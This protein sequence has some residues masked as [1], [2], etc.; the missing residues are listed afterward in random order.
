M[1]ATAVP[2]AAA[3]AASALVQ[4][5]QCVTCRALPERPFDPADVED[6]VEYR[7]RKPRPVVS[8]GPRSK[9]CKTHERAKERARKLTLRTG[10]KARTFGVPRAIQVALW[11][12]Q[13]SSCPC[14]RKRSTTIPAGV[15]LHHDRGLAR[16]HPHP[17]EEGCLDCVACFLCPSCNRD[18]IGRL[19]RTYR[20][21]ALV[22]AALRSLA[23]YIADP[24]LRRLRTERPD[25][26]EESAA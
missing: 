24:P 10:A 12:Y 18:V 5:H 25:L 6:G 26:F 23:D 8:G 11:E 1:S 2:L 15:T 16:E 19:E 9:V 13:G 17:D 22:V 4:T 3:K 14:G 21:Y 7:P 20:D